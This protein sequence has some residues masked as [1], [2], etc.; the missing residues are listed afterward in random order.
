LGSL[1]WGAGGYGHGGPPGEK[2]ETNMERESVG[3]RPQGVT[4]GV[5]VA[6]GRKKSC[7]L[8]EK[9]FEKADEWGKDRPRFERT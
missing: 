2:K 9:G 8:G 6:Q 5:G 1:P 7:R 4:G 3:R